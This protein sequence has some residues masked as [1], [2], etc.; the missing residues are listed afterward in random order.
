MDRV[1][2]TDAKTRDLLA[3]VFTWEGHDVTVEYLADGTTEAAV[4]EAAAAADALVVDSVTP[5]TERVLRETPVRVVARSGIGVDNVDLTAAEAHGVA[6]VNAPDYCREEVAT[7]ALS[8]LLATWRKLR[9]YDSS[10]RAGEWA[11]EAGTPVERLS[12]ATLGLVA[13]GAIP[14]TLVGLVAGFDLDVVAYDPHVDDGTIREAGAEPVSFE[15]LCA[16]SD[17]VSVH[18]PLTDETDGLIDDAAFERMRP[19]AVLVNVSRGG[20]VD[21]DALARALAS[22]R[23]AGA[24][25]DV[26]AEEPPAALPADHPNLVVTPHVAWYSEEAI[27][28]VAR[29]LARD[30]IRVLRGEE[31]AN[32]VTDGW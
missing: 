25:L 29:T 6:V 1:V 30:V 17:L 2:T 14:R 23:I 4:V 27:E 11:R 21:E 12:E 22:G 15:T 7:H 18:A 3:D 5:V 31:P 20:V 8:L 19:G 16:E 26:L 10:V 28:D 13:F 32:R 9:P 24:G